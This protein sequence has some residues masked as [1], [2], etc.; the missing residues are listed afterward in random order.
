MQGGPAPGRAGRRKALRALWLTVHLY[1]GLAAGLILAVTGLTGSLIAFGGDIDAWLNRQAMIVPAP[2]QGVAARKSVDQILAAAGH[3]LPEGAQPR[4][5][6]LP[7]AADR[8]AAL[9]YLLPSAIS[10]GADDYALFV[11][12]YTLRVTGRE[13]LTRP[14]DPLA[15]PLMAILVDLHWR[16]LAGPPGAVLVGIAA[17][18]LLLSPL[19]GL[20]LWWPAKGRWQAA[21][22]IKWAASAERRNYD[23][24]KLAG[25]ATAPLLL[26]ILFS[27]AYMNLPDRLTPLVELFSPA[28]GW[29]EGA[30]SAPTADG[31]RITAGDAAALVDRLFPDG[32][33]M[34]IGLPDGPEGTYLVR[35]RAPD[36]VTRA[37]PHRQVWLDQYD[38]RI[39]AVNDPA[40]YSAGQRFLEWQYPLHSGEAFGTAGKVVVLLVGLAC[41]TLY[42][43]GLIRWWQKRRARQRSR[44]R[45]AAPSLRL[46]DQAVDVGQAGGPAALPLPG[47]ALGR[48]PG[49]DP[50]GSGS[51][52]VP[53]FGDHLGDPGGTVGA[54]GGLEFR[55]AGAQHLGAHHVAAIRRHVGV[56]IGHVG[57]HQAHHPLAEQIAPG[58]DF[59]AFRPLGAILGRRRLKAGQQ[60]ERQGRPSSHRTLPLPRNTRRRVTESG[61]FRPTKIPAQGRDDEDL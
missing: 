8:A 2:P 23:L 43:T 19:T 5:L 22:R 10:G 29:P 56:L 7:R 61:L 11:D 27:G 33:L 52:A 54:A 41:P 13:L 28:P 14:D 49:A 35:K 39:L 24:H 45:R 31:R 50:G 53:V 3:A 57:A 25:L 48:D 40:R 58:G 36:E 26:V 55:P 42:V 12:P 37:Y 20:V 46:V 32:E 38:G 15:A 16:L 6:E 47:V 30:R 34:G 60:Q 18:L 1:L 51:H 44:R 9:L 17:L 21:F 4:Y 59:L